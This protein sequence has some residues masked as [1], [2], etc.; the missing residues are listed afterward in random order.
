MTLALLVALVGAP[1]A[2]ADMLMFEVLPDDGK[3]I[4]YPVGVWS[5]YLMRTGKESYRVRVAL[6]ARSED[7]RET[8]ET[9]LRRTAKATKE[10]GTFRTIVANPIGY[11]RR[12]I[13]VSI[14]L[15][16][17]G[18]M[19]LKSDERAPQPVPEPRQS[20]GP[21]DVQV[22][23]GRF[24]A[25]RRRS[26]AGNVEEWVNFDVGPTGLVRLRQTAGTGKGGRSTPG[27]VELVAHGMGAKPTVLG[28]PQPPV[29]L[30]M[31]RYWR[32]LAAA[33]QRR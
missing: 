30:A 31:I 5:E 27:L 32:E 9:E 6:V 17:L 21:A 25:E 12:L 26:A 3:P 11:P 1:P 20:L 4:H 29:D 10:W 2:R 18:L 16:G 23:A 28:T 14:L 24:K 8:F 7:G 22:P 33:S 13:E 15:P 19:A